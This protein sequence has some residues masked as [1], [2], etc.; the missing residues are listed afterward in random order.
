MT[1]WLSALQQHQPGVIGFEMHPFQPGGTRA[2]MD[3]NKA[4][5]LLVKC[6]LPFDVCNL[7]D[8]NDAI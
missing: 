4:K 1:G 5:G 7:Y 8:R 6:Q 3:D 2:F